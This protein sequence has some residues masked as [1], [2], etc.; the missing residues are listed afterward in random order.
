[1]NYDYFFWWQTKMLPDRAVALIREYSKPLTCPHWRRGS[2]LANL[3]L[4]SPIMLSINNYIT[5]HLDS[6]LN[7]TNP[8]HICRLESKFYKINMYY[9]GN[10]IQRYGEDLLLYTHPYLY[11]PPHANF[12]LYAKYYLKNTGHL[13]ITRCN[14]NAHIWYE[15]IYKN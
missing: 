13:Q 9:A 1:L 12:Y 11:Y 14:R 5:R 7:S 3:I 15:Y 8:Y 2:P 4:E 10:Y 6:E